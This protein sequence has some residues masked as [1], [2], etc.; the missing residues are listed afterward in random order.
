MK[1]G[2]AWQHYRSQLVDFPENQLGASLKGLDARPLRRRRGD[3]PENQLGASLKALAAKLAV[4]REAPL[5]RE[6]TRGLIEGRSLVGR[7]ALRRRYFPENQLGASLKAG[8]VTGLHALA[9][10]FPENQL[11]ASLKGPAPGL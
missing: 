3:F 7:D 2:R 11:G 10:D 8:E 5:P 1:G 6:P 4:M 9:R